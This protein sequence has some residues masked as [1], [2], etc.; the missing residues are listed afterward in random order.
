[1]PCLRM[2]VECCFGEEAQ[3][4]PYPL[5]GSGLSFFLYCQSSQ[6]LKTP[7]SPAKGHPDICHHQLCEGFN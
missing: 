4:F 1:M 3:V 7:G 5:P 2:D 6:A